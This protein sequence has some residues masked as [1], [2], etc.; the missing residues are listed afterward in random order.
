M[1]LIWVVVVDQFGVISLILSNVCGSMSGTFVDQVWL[2]LT[3]FEENLFV[4][5]RNVCGSI[6]SNFKKF[7]VTFLD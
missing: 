4:N 7:G 6:L 3:K 5:L 1:G 2:I